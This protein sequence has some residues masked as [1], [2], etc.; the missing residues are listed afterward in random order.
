MSESKAWL[1]VIIAG[2]LEI[3]WASGFKYEAVPTLLVIV[4]LLGSFDLLI[5]STKVLPIGTVY[6]VFAGMG[7]IGTAIVES[8]ISGA[9]ISSLRIVFILL[10]LASIVGLK[11]TAKGSEN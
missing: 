6:A 4:S 5:R 7:T 11:L 8:I 3:I 9:A 1:Y 2:L 10:L